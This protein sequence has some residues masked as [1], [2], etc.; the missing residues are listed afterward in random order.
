MVAVQQGRVGVG[1][2]RLS[3]FPAE[4][5]RVLDAG[6]HA[7]CAGRAADVRGNPGQE[8]RS[9]LLGG[10]GRWYGQKFVAHAG[11]CSRSCPGWLV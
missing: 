8:H 11:S 1:L 3:E 5:H 6:V 9:G 7:L 10:G 4:V 2:Q